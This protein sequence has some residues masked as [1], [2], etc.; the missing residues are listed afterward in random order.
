MRS[1]TISSGVA[2]AKPSARME[3]MNSG[4]TSWMRNAIS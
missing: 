3:A 4:V 1:A 2:R